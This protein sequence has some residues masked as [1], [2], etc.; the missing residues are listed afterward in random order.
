MTLAV[1]KAHL[2]TLFKKIG[3]EKDKHTAPPPSTENRASVAWEYFIADFAQSYWKKRRDK[4]KKMAD[5]MGLLVPAPVGD[6]AMCYVNEHLNIVAKTNNPSQRLNENALVMKLIRDHSMTLTSAQS[7]L[8]ACRE[9]NN[10]ATTYSIVAAET[11][12]S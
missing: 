1:V 7:L 9:D 6:S 3:T 4:A 10:P 5:E 8:N 2:D 11:P 12:E